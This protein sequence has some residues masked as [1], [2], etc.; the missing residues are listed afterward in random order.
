MPKQLSWRNKRIFQR[1]QSLLKAGAC[2]TLFSFENCVSFGI[3]HLQQFRCFNMLIGSYAPNRSFEVSGRKT[4]ITWSKP[5]CVRGLASG[6]L[7][8]CDNGVNLWKQ[9]VL[10][11]QLSRWWKSQFVQI[12]IFSSV[13]ETH[14][15]L[16]RNQFVLE[17]E[18]S[19][20]LLPYENWCT[21]R[22]DYL[23]QLRLFKEEVAFV[24]YP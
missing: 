24:C 6:T 18:G 9:Y 3:E 4:Y 23:L 8:P 13:E 1:N 17:P 19:S 22:M 7:Y 20:T 15:L 14:G 11:M 16:E 2:S 12:G 5:K 21:L 10:Q